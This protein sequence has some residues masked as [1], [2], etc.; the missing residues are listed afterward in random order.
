M[1]RSIRLLNLKGACSAKTFAVM[2][3][4]FY[5]M[6]TACW[7]I[8]LPGM[9]ISFGV[10]FAL[11]MRDLFSCVTL[12]VWRLVWKPRRLDQELAEERHQVSGAR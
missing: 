8:C 3:W 4:E 6:S 10:G 1:L 5:D 2:R 12:A 9:S 11:F 7:M